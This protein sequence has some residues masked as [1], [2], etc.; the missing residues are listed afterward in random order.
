[1]DIPILII[2]LFMIGLGFL[3]KSFPN[4][5]AGYNT[6]SE[7]KKKNID[8][9]GLS[10]Y[11]RNG[12]IIIGF[13]ILIG[14]YVFNLIGLTMIAHSIVV[15]AILI[16]VTIMAVNA[17]KF[18]NNKKKRTKLTYFILGGLVVVFVMGL[19][20]YGFIPSKTLISND[21]IRYT[22]MYGIELKISDIENIE[23]TD[24]SI[25]KI[26]TRT[27][28]FSFG[29]IH[30]GTFKLDKFGKCRLLLHS[31]KPPYLII[32]KSDGEKIIVNFKD[33]TETKE[34]YNKIVQ[35]MK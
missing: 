19:I 9:K 12:L 17:Q 13:T 28:G 30:K 34:T 27:N 29:P 16:G 21:T 15:F 33:K 32:S 18:D 14:Y 23:L 5:I 24:K 10:T 8:I 1:M 2:G 4:L 35:L 25:P 6:M 20:T 7:D 11:M 3:V 31:D 26:K 22:G